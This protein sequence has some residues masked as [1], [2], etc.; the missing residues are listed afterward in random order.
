MN[1]DER[2][3]GDNNEVDAEDAAAKEAETEEDGYCG[4][5]LAVAADAGECEGEKS[6]AILFVRPGRPYTSPLSRVALT[7]PTP[8]NAP[9]VTVVPPKLVRSAYGRRGCFAA[10]RCAAISAALQQL[11]SN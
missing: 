6:R 3:D 1:E 8:D 7:A 10:T 5:G 4:D 9:T 11:A 2:D